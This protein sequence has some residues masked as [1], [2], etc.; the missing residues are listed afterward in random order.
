[1]SQPHVSHSWCTVLGQSERGIVSK[2][3]TG[4]VVDGRFRIEAKMREGKFGDFWRATQL[5]NGQTVAVKL[6]KPELFMDGEAIRRFN[7]ETKLLTS[8][9]HP[10]LLRVLEAGR[11]EMG[12][13]FIVTE[14]REGRLL[15]DDI[16][17]LAL[18]V[19]QVCHIGAQIARVLASAHRRGIVHR[20]LNPDAIMLCEEEGDPNRVKV[21]DFGLAHL[22]PGSGEPELTQVGQRLGNPEYMAPEYI[23]EFHLD[24]RTDLYILGVM[25]FEMLCGQPPFVGRAMHVLSAHIEKEPWAPSDLAEQEVPKFLDGLVLALLAKSPDDRPQD[26]RQVARAFAT[27]MWPAAD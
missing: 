3:Q 20:G 10:N 18:P 21:L 24:A 23:E 27:R 26:A 1:M 8:F 25:V 22:T 6:L 13:P 16:C 4:Q 19:D 9:S 12:D 17:D 7:R 11:T 14:F 15:S 2:D 5:N